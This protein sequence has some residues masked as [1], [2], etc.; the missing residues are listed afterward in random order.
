MITITKVP[1]N[2]NDNRSGCGSVKDIYFYFH[3]VGNFITN[4]SII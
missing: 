4:L 3:S 2:N 1:S